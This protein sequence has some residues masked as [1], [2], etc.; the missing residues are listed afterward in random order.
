M[1]RFAQIPK[2]KFKRSKFNRDHGY[3][4][5]LDENYVVPIYVDEVLPGDTHSLKCNIFCRLATPIVPFLDNVHVST[6]FF[7]VPNR[8]VWDNW[9]KFMGEQINPEDSIDYTVPKVEFNVTPVKW[10]D[11]EQTTTEITVYNSDES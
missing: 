9:Q 3:K 5:T 1:N 10:T 7:F 8:L 4:T 2:V 6:F 11:G